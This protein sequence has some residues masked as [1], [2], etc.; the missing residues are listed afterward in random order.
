VSTLVNLIKGSRLSSSINS[1]W[2]GKV[3]NIVWVQNIDCTISIQRI[4]T[5]KRRVNTNIKSSRVKINRCGHLDLSAISARSTTIYDCDVDLRNIVYQIE[6]DIVCIAHEITSIC[7]LHTWASIPKHTVHAGQLKESGEKC[8]LKQ[9][10]K[11]NAFEWNDIQRRTQS[12]L[13]D[14][15]RQGQGQG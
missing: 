14:I 5:I 12:N 9:Q 4:T 2:V 8:K 11:R 15:H 1:I 10:D 6:G 13:P 7:I 3:S